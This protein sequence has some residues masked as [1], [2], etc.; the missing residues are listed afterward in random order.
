MQTGRLFARLGQLV[1]A[2]AVILLHP[3]AFAQPVPGY[4]PSTTHIF[5]AGG[6]R[7]TSVRVRVGTECA[8]PMSR[9]TIDGEGVSAPE[10]LSDAAE[11]CS[12]PSPRRMPTETPITYPRE[13]QSQ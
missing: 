11:A 9:F 5:P 10:F 3:A 1:I 7:G 2:L 12:E 8:P 4:A 13:W 6:Q